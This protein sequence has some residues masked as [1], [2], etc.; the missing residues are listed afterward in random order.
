LIVFRVDVT[1]H[2]DQLERARVMFGDLSE[3]SRRVDGVVHFDILQDPGRPTRF[4][5]IEVYAD[6]SALDRQGSL[7]EVEQ[8]KKAFP[9]LLID[10]PHG[11]IFHVSA[12]E[13]WPS[14]PDA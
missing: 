12:S 8:V 5:S 10:G 11:M 14:T 1:V 7:P 4:V 6:Q 3:L 13:P 2:E 9:T